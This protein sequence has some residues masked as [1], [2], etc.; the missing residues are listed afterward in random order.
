VIDFTDTRFVSREYSNA[1]DSFRKPTRGDILYSLVGS[2]GMAIPVK[3]DREFCIQRHIAVLRPHDLSPTAYLTHVLNSS[4]VLGQA[5]AV[6]TGTAQ[7]TVPLA[8]LRKFVIPLPLPAEQQRIV[9][10]VERRLSVVEELEAIVTANLQRAIRL[11]QSILQ[12]AFE[13]TL[14]RTEKEEPSVNDESLPLAA[15]PPGHYE[16][17]R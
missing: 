6:A 11:R 15:E 14:L 3:T 17:H 16:Q 9:A 8:G 1:V 13:G 10:E 5:T 4:F 12:R 7:K 2:Y